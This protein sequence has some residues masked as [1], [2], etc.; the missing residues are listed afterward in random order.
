MTRDKSCVTQ[1]QFIFLLDVYDI[2][3]TTH[4]YLQSVAVLIPRTELLGGLLL[5]ICL[6]TCTHVLT[7]FY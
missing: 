1:T 5:Y 2:K 7:H 4:N 6:N 3:V